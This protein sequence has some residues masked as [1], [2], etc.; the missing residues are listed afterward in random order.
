V[1]TEF[2]PSKF[3]SN[4]SILIF[5][6]R[7]VY[8]DWRRRLLC[9]TKDEGLLPPRQM[10]RPMPP[11]IADGHFASSS[12][13][14]SSSSSSSNSASKEIKQSKRR[15][16]SDAYQQERSLLDGRQFR[17]A[18]ERG[19]VFSQC[20]LGYCY[21]RG[22]EVEK[23]FREAERWYQKAAQQGGKGSPLIQE[24]IFLEG[25]IN[26]KNSNAHAD[27][28]EWCYQL[29][30][31]YLRFEYPSELRNIHKS[32]L[33]DGRAM[34]EEPAAKGML[35]AMYQLA[36][37]YS[38]CSRGTRR[39]VPADHERARSLFEKIRQ[40][41]DK[42]ARYYENLCY[43][44]GVGVTENS[45][46][47]ADQERLNHPALSLELLDVDRGASSSSSSASKKIEQPNRRPFSDAY[48]Q[49]R[50]L[51]DGRQFR[52]A[53]E[54]GDVLSQC[55]LGYCHLRGYEVEKDFC[56]AERWYQ[57]AAQ[58]EREGS[59]L[60]QEMIFLEGLIESTGGT[61]PD[62]LEWCYQLGMLYL[63]FEHPSELR[64]IGKTSLKN[65]RAMLEKPAAEG[66]LKAMYQLAL[67]CPKGKAHSLFKKIKQTEGTQARYY[68]GLCYYNGVGVTE[69][70]GEAANLFQQ[71]AA[72]EEK[73]AVQAILFYQEA[74]AQGDA[75]AERALGQTAL[76]L[77]L[78]QELE[79][80][81]KALIINREVSAYEKLAEAV[82]ALKIMVER[83][84]AD[85]QHLY[86]LGSYYQYGTVVQKNIAQAVSLY[87]VAASQGQA[88]A[89][90]ALAQLSHYNSPSK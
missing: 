2:D 27:Y 40:T 4:P 58:Q 36:L 49:E 13:S 6:H 23:N 45:G 14:G 29:G 70:S 82:E 73:D 16:F 69:S 83:K 24:M 56:A 32:S 30:M 21:L 65:G 78:S 57:K 90:Q 51:L 55:T 25:L 31:L 46:Q 10:L 74:A 54:R 50:S 19:D 18:A 34:L 84:P 33:K 35:K 17:V 59:P 26:K 15:I 81:C 64:S 1:S 37:A 76:S 22:Y 60:I 39:G 28:L 3:I 80:R 87:Q 47:A 66:M 43:Y 79:L 71:A 38:T 42:Q 44:N 62:Y 11:P 89:K 88:L 72:R 85:V 61:H 41:K 5:V 67:V 53:A 12:S 77:A 86:L 7:P 52:A 48:E 9:E 20:Q 68:E 63:R 75:F 8:N